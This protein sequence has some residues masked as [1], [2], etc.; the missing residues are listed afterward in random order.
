MRALSRD[1]A[2]W[3]HADGEFNMVSV[4]HTWIVDD[5]RDGYRLVHDAA[6]R[7]K[8]LDKEQP[9]PDAGN[10]VLD[11][12]PAH[13]AVV[14]ADGT[15]ISVNQAWR[16]FAQAN[17]LRDPNHGVGTNYNGSCGDAVA[18]GDNDATVVDA[19]LRAV[20]SGQLDVFTHDYPCHSPT[21]QRWFALRVTA[22]NDGH[23]GRAVVA[24]EDITARK[25]A[26]ERERLLSV[27]SS[28]L[29]ESLDPET[30]L[31][32]LVLLLVPTIADWC[33]VVLVDNDGSFKRV[34]VV[35]NDPAK[36]SLAAELMQLGIDPDSSSG[37][38]ATIRSGRSRIDSDIRVNTWR[39]TLSKDYIRV[40][41][42]LGI[43]SQM[44]V[45]LV[46]RGRVIGGI[47]FIASD[48]GR[49]YTDAD[50]SFAEEVARLAALAID[51]ARLHDDLRQS[52]AR[53]RA[54]I[55]QIPGTVYLAAPDDLGN[56]LYQSPQIAS[57]L[58]YAAEEWTE[59]P[60]YWRTRLHPD[61]VERVRTSDARSVATGEPFTSDYRMFKCNGDLTWFRDHG[62]LIRDE[63]G[64]PLHW[65][66]VILDITEQKQA[67]TGMRESEERFRSAFEDAPIGMVIQRLEGEFLRVNPA[68]CAM[69]GY[70]A[71]EL[72][73][74]NGTVL[75]H[76]DDVDIA[77]PY[78]EQIKRGEISTF[79]TEKRYL[80]KN[81]H[82][83]WVLLSVAVVWDADGAPLHCIT[84]VQDVSQQKELQAIL[85]KQALYDQ[86][87]G[88]PSRALL[89]DR[90]ARALA[91]AKRHDRNVAVLF[92]DLDNFKV[93]ND[94]L[95]HAHGDNLLKQVA[96]RLNSCLRDG[97]TA[98]RLGGDEFAIL[99][100]EVAD[101]EG[102]VEV[103]RRTHECF[104]TPFVLEGRDIFT[105]ASIGIALNSAS[106]AAPND[107][108]R[109]ADVAMYR[110]KV[111]GK[112]QYAV[113]NTA[114]HAD[115]LQRLE[116]E[117]E[118]RHAIEEEQ[119]VVY[120][121]PKV[122]LTTGEAFG[123]EALVRWQHPERG[124]VLPADFITI[125]E[126]TGMIVPLGN[127]VLKEATRQ[128]A[129]WN[130]SMPENR[131]LMMSVNLSARQ[132][133]QPDLVV[134]IETILRDTGL[135]PGQL[136]IEITETVLMEDAG[137][138][139]ERLHALKALGVE[140][141]IDDFG[142]GYSSLAYLQRFPVDVLKIDHSFVAGLGQSEGDTIIVTAIISMA[143]ALGIRVV[144]EGVETQV[145]MEHLKQLGCDWAQ[146]YYFAK[147]LPANAA[148][149]YTSLRCK[150]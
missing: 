14:D 93:V 45:P 47:A 6:G 59:N 22:L 92:L 134:Q 55:E 23:V 77:L 58:G 75:S 112:S 118:L 28:T 16:S 61:N 82:T 8:Q 113:F 87:T 42:A 99:L 114:M 81:G 131:T 74:R 1:D 71:S 69:T 123:M 5:D 68:L 110:A 24:H 36:A 142:T 106:T 60:W 40:H 17:G 140:I 107:L 53:H 85:L 7:A 104:S 138:S 78:L 147:P 9:R 20:L 145:Q 63:R 119:F 91:Q 86:L 2:S 35:H 33:S 15:I 150:T 26:E 25:Q 133:R 94:S 80:H 50:L 57:M 136:V 66:G 79:L 49:R 115:I 62:V 27:I 120:Y 4:L 144:A 116:V 122:S 103:A 76:P 117:Q 141:S 34:A 64:E 129:V 137:E 143:H 121:Q 38:P 48:S 73:G 19:G 95:G 37:L 65:L 88:L 41:R 84:Q 83:I 125:A 127:W 135:R 32:R 70:S 39:A 43:A 109:H 31:R 130:R 139:V 46:A 128:A 29:Q 54:L 18:S 105:T 51:N 111:E 56:L 67:E 146:G 148:F 124:L 21:E 100:P 126:E 101:I 132:F 90:T 89:L 108:L 102:A 10:P 44:N 3:F 30:T 72:V 98:A 11:A 52:E 96:A 97:D 12:L 149:P 13:I